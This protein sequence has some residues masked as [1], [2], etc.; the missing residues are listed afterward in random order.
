M[1]R[2]IISF[3]LVAVAL[4]SQA[5]NKPVGQ[6]DVHAAFAPPAQKVIE[7]LNEVYYTSGG[8]LFS[9]NPQTDESRSYNVGNKLTD[10]GISN[11]FY[12][13]DENYLLICY[14]S[15]NLDF[16]Y[17]DGRLVN[18]S[19]IKDSS[20][21]PPLTVTDVAF[22]PGRLWVGTEFGL[23]EINTERHEVIQS[24]IFGKKVNGV[25]T[26][27]DRLVIHCDDSLRYV[28]RGA[29]IN[30]LSRFTPMLRYTT[31]QELA[32]I[33]ENRLISRRNDQNDY[34]TMIQFDFDK[35]VQTLWH[36][37]AS[38][39]QSY[40]HLNYSPEGD[41]FYVADNKLYTIDENLREKLL[42]PLSEEMAS[43]V[44][45][46]CRGA[47]SVWSLSREG[48]AR[49]LFDGEGGV[50]MLMDRYMPE[51]LSV[52]RVYYFYPSADK[53]S[54]YLMT[55]G[56]T[57][58]KFGMYTTVERNG[59]SNIENAAVIDLASGTPRDLTLF[60]V[61]TRVNK[62]N[63]ALK[64]YATAHTALAPDP[65]DPDTYYLSTA[66]DGV[67]KVSGG[68]LVGRYDETNTPLVVF[69]N[70]V[71]TYGASIDRAGNLWI[72]C[73]HNNYANPPVIILPA[74]KRK[75]DPADVKPSDWIQPDFASID[76]W[77]G[78]DVTF[79]HCSKGG[80]TFIIDSEPGNKLVAYDTR[81]TLNNFDDDRFVLW[82]TF[83]D[84]DGL[85][86]SPSR[87]VSMVEDLNGQVWLGTSEGVALIANPAQ[88]LN[89]STT[90]S[91][92]KVPRND[93]SN[94]ADYLLGTDVVN[95]ISVDAANRKW[96]ATDASGLYM[97][98]PSGNEILQSFTVDNSPLPSNRVNA[99]YCDP[100]SSTVYIGTR[101]GLFTYSSDA[102]P[103]REDY[104]DIYAYPNPVRPEYQGDIYVRGL[105]ANSLV[106][107]T[108]SAGGLIHQ[109]R[110]E[111]G[112]FVWDGRNSAGERVPSGIY[113]VFA[114]QN[115]SGST[116]GAVAKIMIVN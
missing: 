6:W 68:K 3:L 76:Y 19:D 1:H 58:Y 94:L 113:Y 114:S 16:L 89:P 29:M 82:E 5:V 50:T 36:R 26:M 79:L 112:L 47:A 17:D 21:T 43:M 52:G 104:S 108:D 96:L 61:E 32:G 11:I 111:G 53:K 102:T 2:T 39:H 28:N 80:I 99:V 106:K 91:H 105:M 64:G 38:P 34:L 37:V 110:S 103:A 107:I 83:T 57:A 88:M 72:G 66:T 44:I 55:L 71:I 10:S 22:G 78:Q 87:S 93:G 46:T 69:D 62:N 67:F 92:I 63:P 20:I 13:F 84:Q 115:A 54:L 109:G 100:Q 101:H 30:T 59:R 48:L 35:N 27:G 85:E 86:F 90:I 75:L 116:S 74:D 77:G 24:G 49:H 65:D 41:M 81:G 25:T 9:Y 7:T 51:Q 18:M 8:M 4:C 42:S 15:G 60:P 73:F 31:P 12:N 33:D 14:E 40:S 97:V 45:G 56:S 95:S 70:R 23:V 98:S